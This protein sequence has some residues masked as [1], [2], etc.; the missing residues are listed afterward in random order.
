MSRA[1]WIA[2]GGSRPTHPTERTLLSRTSRNSS[3][4]WMSLGKKTQ[5]ASCMI[6]SSTKHPNS[7]LEEK[8]VPP[9]ARI[10]LLIAIVSTDVQIHFKKQSKFGIQ[11]WSQS[12][13]PS[14][15]R[16]WNR[17]CGRSWIAGYIY[18]HL[19]L[20]SWIVGYSYNYLQIARQL[21]R[22]IAG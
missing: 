1:G 19:Y 13:S 17:T 15:S 20:D 8:E 6:R 21:D 3:A 10:R 4:D 18:T 7:P 2:A 12:W 9:V 16:S 5:T 22:C 14:W 11:R